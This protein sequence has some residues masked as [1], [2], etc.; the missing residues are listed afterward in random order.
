[1]PDRNARLDL[2]CVTAAE[3]IRGLTARVCSDPLKDGHRDTRPLPQNTPLPRALGP[4]VQT[5]SPQDAGPIGTA[6]LQSAEKQT[7]LPRSQGKFSYKEKVS[8]NPSP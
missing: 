2:L 4:S 8:I 7:L 5:L 1:M 3:E 6:G